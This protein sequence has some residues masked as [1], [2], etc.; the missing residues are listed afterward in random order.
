MKHQ[1][2]EHLQC[3]CGH[4]KMLHLHKCQVK[5]C[6]CNGFIEKISDSCFGDTQLD[7]ISEE[8]SEYIG[9]EKQ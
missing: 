9:P 2:T 7:A 8:I 3:K 6:K 5:N 1:S 4:A